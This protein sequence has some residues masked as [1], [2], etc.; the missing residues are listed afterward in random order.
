[1]AGQVD[2]IGQNDV[3]VQYVIVCNMSVCYQQVVLAYFG[4][5]S[6]RGVLVDCYIFFYGSIVVN[7]GGGFFVFEFQVL[8]DVGNDSFW[9]NFVVFINLCV[10]KD[11]DRRANLGVIVNFNIFVNIS[12]GANYDIF[13]NFSFWMNVGYGV[14]IVCIYFMSV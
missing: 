7:F 2:V 8:W 12:E 14:V 4:G 1:M 10:F 9:K 5:I 11:G 3:V 13:F 6:V